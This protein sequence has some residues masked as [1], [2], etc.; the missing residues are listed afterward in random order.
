MTKSDENKVKKEYGNEVKRDENKS[1]IFEGKEIEVKKDNGEKTEKNEVRSKKEDK[2]GIGVK[3][4]EK[5]VEYEE[6]KGSG[7]KRDEKKEL[8]VEKDEMVK[9]VKE[10]ENESGIKKDEKDKHKVLEWYPKTAEGGNSEEPGDLKRN[11]NEIGAENGQTNGQFDPG[12]S[13]LQRR[14]SL[15]KDCEVQKKKNGRSRSKIRGKIGEIKKVDFVPPQSLPFD[16]APGQVVK[17]DKIRIRLPNKVEEVLELGKRLGKSDKSQCKTKSRA[18]RLTLYLLWW[19]EMIVFDPGG[20]HVK[21]T[22][23]NNP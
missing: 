17:W 6:R 2:N 11:R 5:E 14:K 13:R 15:E 10:D 18:K 8:K 23:G 9:V 20:R 16:V 19:D 22:P 1:R 4:D 21:L 7:V 3:K 12:G